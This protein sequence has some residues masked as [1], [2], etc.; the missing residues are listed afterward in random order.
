MNLYTYSGKIAYPDGAP[1]IL[2]IAVSLAREGRY[3]GAGVHWWP[4]ALH[5]F[6]VC[7]LLPSPW[8]LHGLL[9]D[10]AECV[11][12]DVPKPAKSKAVSRMEDEIH[13][14]IYESLEIPWPSIEV[15]KAV[16]TADKRALHGEVAVVGTKALRKVYPIDE[17]AAKIVLDY[18]RQY[19]FADCLIADGRVVKE[20]IYRYGCYRGGVK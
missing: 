19:N 11:M 8:R 16:H 20:F 10:A 5:T 13:Q 12:G 7:D 18:F 2:D 4:V 15:W 6:V 3:A 1:S 9:H 17:E 14:R